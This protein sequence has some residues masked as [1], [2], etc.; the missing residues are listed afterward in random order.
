MNLK[1]SKM[2]EVIGKYILLNN[3]GPNGAGFLN[4]I[5]SKQDVAFVGGSNIFESPYR[6]F[7]AENIEVHLSLLKGTP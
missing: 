7:I 3:S 2:G 6:E 4:G 5:L 1:V